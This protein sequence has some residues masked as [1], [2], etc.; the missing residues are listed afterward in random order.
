MLAVFSCF[1]F[2]HGRTFVFDDLPPDVLVQPTA[3]TIP[4]ARTTLR[5]LRA[6]NGIIQISYARLAT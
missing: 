6:K 2:D 4:T 5:I 3:R 1:G